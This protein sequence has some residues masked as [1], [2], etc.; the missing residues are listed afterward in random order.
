[1][2]LI[3]GIIQVLLIGSTQVTKEELD[4]AIKL[5]KEEPTSNGCLN[6]FTKYNNVA[7][8]ECEKLR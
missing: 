5:C 6:T 3:C 1:M 2:L 4:L 8:I 7:Q